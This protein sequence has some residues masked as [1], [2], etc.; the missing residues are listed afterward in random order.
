M[1]NHHITPPKYEKM[2]PPCTDKMLSSIK[3]IY[4]KQQIIGFGWHVNILTK[5]FRKRTDVV[6]LTNHR[7]FPVAVGSTEVLNVNFWREVKRDRMNFTRSDAQNCRVRVY[8]TA[9]C[10]NFVLL[11]SDTKMSCQI[12]INFTC[13]ICPNELFISQTRDG[14]KVAV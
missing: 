13:R 7:S 11:K 12:V 9:L 2:T 1:C 14:Q 4:E 5:H 10:R 6:D 3:N 8:N